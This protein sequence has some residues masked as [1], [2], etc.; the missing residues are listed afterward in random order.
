MPHPWWLFWPSALLM[1]LKQQCHLTLEIGCHWVLYRGYLISIIA[2]I[3]SATAMFFLVL[4]QHELLKL[5]NDR[6]IPKFPF[7]HLLSVFSSSFLACSHYGFLF[8]PAPR[9]NLMRQKGGVCKQGW[10]HLANF[11]VFIQLLFFRDSQ[12]CVLSLKKKRD[13][14]KRKETNSWCLTT[15]SDPI[16]KHQPVTLICEH[17]C[18][19]CT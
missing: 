13:R 5:R 3:S 16:I 9:T 14:K 11:F 6:I 1:T 18:H 4:T 12:F 7:Y 2:W 8:N 15:P 10:D 17:P 19:G